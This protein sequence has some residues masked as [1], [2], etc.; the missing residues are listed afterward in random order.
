VIKQP[1][2]TILAFCDTCREEEFLI[3][4]WQDTPWADGV[5]PPLDLQAAAEDSSAGRVEG[6]PEQPDNHD[7]RLER[8]LTCL[9][10]KMR[11]DAVVKLIRESQTPSDVLQAV[12]AS[13]PPPSTIDVVEQFLPDLMDAWNATPRPDL[14]ERAPDDIRA[15]AGA[16]RHQPG[17][18]DP[19]PCGSGAKYKKCCLQRPLH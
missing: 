11:P 17:R 9:G 16:G 19:C 5:M 13:A 7:L 3:H 6:R 2:D 14:G 4:D 10:S 18:N 8:A 12:L 1:D 15:N